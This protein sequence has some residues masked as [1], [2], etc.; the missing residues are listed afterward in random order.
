VQGFSGAGSGG[1]RG[2]A[3]ENVLRP[4]GGERSGQWAVEALPNDTRFK[5]LQCL[6]AVIGHEQDALTIAT[7]F[8]P[9][10]EERSKAIAL[11]QR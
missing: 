7:N 3:A 4:P 1:V 5:A 2:C 10:E 6:L 11:L 9:D 8:G